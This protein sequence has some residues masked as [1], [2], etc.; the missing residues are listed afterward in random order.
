MEQTVAK[1]AFD[2]AAAIT[3]FLNWGLLLFLFGYTWRTIGKLRD[4]KVEKETFKVVEKKVDEKLDDVKKQ[5]G[6]L[7]SKMDKQQT[8]ITKMSTD[9]KWIVDAIKRNGGGS[10]G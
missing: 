5:N 6:K 8:E 2:W 9:I 4:T 7:H 10:N 3:P 1:V